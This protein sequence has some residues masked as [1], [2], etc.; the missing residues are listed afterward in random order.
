ME[1][2]RF[3]FVIVT[4]MLLSFVVGAFGGVIVDRQVL[5][6][7]PFGNVPATGNTITDQGININ[8]IQEAWNTI[9][10][11]YVDRSAVKPKDLTYGAISGMVDALGDTGHSR[12]L[13]PDM[14]QQE[15]SFT[16]GELEGIGVEVQI[17]NG[18]LVIV[19]PIDGSPAQKAGLQPGDVISKVNGE[20]LAGLP[21]SEMIAKIKGPA[22]TSV[23]LT[24]QQSKTGA[25]RVVTLQRAK[26]SLHS[27]NWQQ[28]PGTT[29]AHVRVSAFSK[30]V[31]SD[32]I[33]ALKEIQSQKMTGIVLDLRNNPGGLLQ[34]AVTVAS[35][36][37]PD[38]NVMEEKDASGAIRPL[39][40]TPGG[41]AY[42]IPMV[43]LINQG[44]ASASEI[45]AGAIQDAKRAQLVGESTFGTGTVLNQFNL[46]DGSALLL[47]TEEWLT[48]SGRVIW[49]KGIQPD[50]SVTLPVGASP[51]NPISEEG[52]NPQRLAASQDTQLLKALNLLGQ[53][54]TANRLPTQTV[55]P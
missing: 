13:S 1:R 2:N 32:L 8:L 43:V 4:V 26:I 53:P 36:F 6:Y 51:L 39:P 16:Q 49:H 54:V 7:L 11:I 50:V 46:S 12:F 42:K 15:N 45:V 5:R 29:L 27:V 44:S 9:N 3:A 22:G 14:V 23:Q 37:L 40:V 31:G 24:I 17:T 25:E 30:G 48:P 47:A 19:A 20:D 34:E 35:Q 55:V 18:E 21:L 10:H 41:V 28:I 52:M 33:Q 38:G